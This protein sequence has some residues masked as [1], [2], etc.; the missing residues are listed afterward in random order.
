MESWSNRR[1]IQGPEYRRQNIRNCKKRIR[2]AEDSID[3]LW[4]TPGRGDHVFVVV[5]YPKVF[6]AASL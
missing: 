6:L 3:P 4:P 5:F 1:R 2:N